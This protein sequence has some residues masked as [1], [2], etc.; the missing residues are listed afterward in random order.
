MIEELKAITNLSLKQKLLRMLI[1]KILQSKVK[2]GLGFTNE[3]WAD[4]I[5]KEFRKPKYLRKVKVFNTDDIWTADLVIMPPE[6]GYKY[7]LTVMDI[8]TRYAWAMPQKTKTANET[9]ESFEGIIKVTNRKP[10]KLWVDKGTEFNKVKELNIV[11]Y[12]TE[13]FNKAVMIERFNRTLTNKLFKQFTIQGNQKWLKI[14]LPIL[15]NYNNKIHSSINETPLNATKNPELIKNVTSKN[16]YENENSNI[17]MKPKF[18]INERV[19]IFKYKNHFEKG[20][21]GYWTNEISTISKIN[22]TSPITYE[23]KD[24]DNEPIYGTFYSNE[25]QATF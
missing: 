13:N 10:M 11:L 3:E 6:K 20:Y 24:L 22:K 7:I 5:H 2:F 15:K 9:K 21:N 14:L 8:Y 4:E 12:H 17:P 16:N 18:K 1:I 19:R 25:L 23:I